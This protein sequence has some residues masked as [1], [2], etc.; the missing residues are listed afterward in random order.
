[1]YGPALQGHNIA[2][3]D[4]DNELVEI[5]NDED[6]EI[7]LEEINENQGGRATKKV[8]IKLVPTSTSFS[9]EERPL[10]NLETKLSEDAISD[11]IHFD[12]QEEELRN[13]A[14][15]KEEKSVFECEGEVEE[16]KAEIKEDTAEEESSPFNAEEPIFKMSHPIVTNTSENDVLLDIKIDG[17]DLEMTKAMIESIAPLMG[18][19]I[20]SAHISLNNQNFQE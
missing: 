14:A 1:M 12:V 17:N 16:E 20:E 11:L 4:C 18:F 9:V 10:E 3:I 6:W 7:C 13:S 5:V 15:E 2:Y 19:E 8:T